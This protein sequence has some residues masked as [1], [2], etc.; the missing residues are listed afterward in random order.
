[1]T[2]KEVIEFVEMHWEM[3]TEEDKQL[4]LTGEI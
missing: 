4:F 1:M 2:E 3:I